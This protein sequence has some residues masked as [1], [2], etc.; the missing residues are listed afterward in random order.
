MIR[1]KNNDK[2]VDILTHAGRFSVGYYGIGSVRAHPARY[3]FIDIKRIGIKGLSGGGFM[4]AEAVLQKPYNEFFT[5]AVASSGNHDNNIY[6]NNWAERYHGLK[7][8]KV[9]KETSGKT[10]KTKASKKRSTKRPGRHIETTGDEPFAGV[11]KSKAV[12]AVKPKKT[13]AIARKPKTVIR[14]SKT[15][16]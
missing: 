14:K 16:G 15:V 12:R 3:S 4:S 6:N 8:V 1:I 13:V 2:R 10:A 5:A 11:G 7:V 9:E